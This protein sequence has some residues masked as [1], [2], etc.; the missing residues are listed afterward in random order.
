MYFVDIHTHKLYDKNHIQLKNEYPYRKNYF[1]TEKNV[2]NIYFSAGMHPWHINEI[3]LELSS[4]NLKQL[5]A[6][7]NIIGIGECG[8]DRSISIDFELQKSIFI[9]Q[10][11]MANQNKLPIIIHC[12]KAYSDIVELYKKHNKNNLPWIIH[13]FN[14]NKTIAEQLLKYNFYLSFGAILLQ[15]THKIEEVL[16]NIPLN[17][18]FFES[19]DKNIDIETIYEKAAAIIACS[20]ENLKKQVYTNFENL[21]HERIILAHKDWIIIR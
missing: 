4:E 21:F 7:K 17:K 6:N 20:V 8:L 18:M 15:P 1:S 5:T 19:D 12:V 14:A 11:E 2:T 10:I 9:R 3:D 13:G 16:K